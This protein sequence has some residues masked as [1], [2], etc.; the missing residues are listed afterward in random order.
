M[1]VQ[2]IQSSRLILLLSLLSIAMAT[3]DVVLVTGASRG[4]GAAIVRRLAQEP[5]RFR[6]YA[7]VR[8]IPAENPTT[9]K[10]I[11][12]DVCKG[13]SVKGAIDNI[14]EAEGKIDYVVN[15]AGIMKYGAHE[16]TTVEEAQEI[17]DV[18][19]FGPLRV[20]HAVLPSM[21]EKKKGHII[22]IGSRSGFRPLP[23]ISV[24]AD[25]KAALLSMSQ[26]MAATLAPWNIRVSVIEPGPVLTDLDSSSAY[27]SQLPPDRDVYYKIFKAADLLA[28]EPGVALGPG[29][30]EV[31]EIAHT[32]MEVIND[33]EPSL[34]YQTTPAIQQQASARA[35]DRTGN[36]DV[37]ELKNILFSAKEKSADEL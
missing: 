13:E 9:F 24:Y 26:I 25:S 15:N 30:Q 21:R 5:K 36:K 2:A 23:S 18:N 28:P 14:L 3:P 7:G 10:Y 8:T 11:E 29:A 20:T 37:E 19:Y 6:I 12:L 16:G 34:R 22:Q 35:V 4:I 27:G 1:F 31:E 32:V 17:F 33:P